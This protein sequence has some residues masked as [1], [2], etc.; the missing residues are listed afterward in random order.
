MPFVERDF[1]INN[2]LNTLLT[3]SMIRVELW[4]P[5][6]SNM[7]AISPPPFL[8]QLSLEIFVRSREEFNSLRELVHLIR[9]HKRLLKLRSQMDILLP[10]RRNSLIELADAI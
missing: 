8:C 7:P 6:A 5:F 2:T 1:L 4:R 10:E 9:K 3:T